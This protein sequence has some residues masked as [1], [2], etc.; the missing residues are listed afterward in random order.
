MADKSTTPDASK[1]TTPDDA[2]S[3]IR[4][5][6]SAARPR[7]GLTGHILPSFW[8]AKGAASAASSIPTLAAP[9]ASEPSTPALPARVSHGRWWPNRISHGESVARATALI[10]ACAALS[11]GIYLYGTL[12][13]PL[14]AHLAPPPLDIGKLTSSAT[15][16]Y[17]ALAGELFLLAICLL[18]GAWG[19]VC[20][21]AG[22]IERQT[23]RGWRHTPRLLGGALFGFPLLALLVQLF[24]YP[25]T[26]VDVFDYVS[27]I[28]V[29][30]IY[31]S[32][33]LTIPPS[34]FP[35]D[36]W[37]PLNTWPTLPASY[38]PLWAL[39]SA[40]VS[41]PA[42]SQVFT[43]VIAQKLLSIVACLGCMALIWL[44]AKRLCPER[45]WQAFVFFAWNPLV[46]FE[47]AA[48]G[49]NDTIMVLF[50]LAGL[51]ALLTPRWYWQALALPL[52]V[53]SVLVKWTSV[54]L[55][56]LAVIYLLRGG[57]LRRWGIVPLSVGAALSIA[58]AV[59][60]IA[61]FWDTQHTWGV[62]L[63]SDLFTS[64]P[65]ALLYTLLSSVYIPFDGQDV[66]AEAVRLLGLSA[67]LLVYLWLLARMAFSWRSERIGPDASL[68]LPQRLIALS[69]ESY[70]W[71]FVLAT[72]WFQPW[73][74]IA[75]LPL[76]ALDPRLL[77]RMRGAF[78]SLGAALSYVIYIFIWIIYWRAEPTFTV[79][80]VA[81]FTIYALP[82]LTRALESWQTRL[83][84]Y[85]TLEL[86]L[87][88]PAPVQADTPRRRR[89]WWLL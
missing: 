72:F 77:A 10:I 1:R 35:H 86:T 52:L 30:T 75:L 28:R 48:N 5:P 21:I 7:S 54:L 8:Q 43:A 22:R 4:P 15:G 67:F 50:M 47:T 12:R 3:A 31:H 51:A 24:M 40:L 87:F 80:F 60:I 58:L 68:T 11:L 84:L 71:Y 79:Q 82:L 89:T 62:L 20:W 66:A 65:P 55:I 49:H 76:A 39:L 44:L 73:Y 57:R 34:V 88:P 36:P 6:G 42:G 64:S 38:G 17:N 83:R 32:N 33:P 69:L 18:F 78:F 9:D 45:R 37:L 19:L 13:F 41:E 2:A 16:A 53:A 81:C 14:A 70:F 29:M 63:Q 61:P 25:I 27:Q 59:P 85:S 23:R 26:A 74:L 56:P 46:L